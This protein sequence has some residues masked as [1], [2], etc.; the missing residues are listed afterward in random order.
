M[1][2][3]DQKKR[4]LNKY[5]ETESFVI[6][7]ADGNH[8]RREGKKEK[9]EGEKEKQE[10]GEKE[11]GKKLRIPST[12]RSPTCYFSVLF[13]TSSFLSSLSLLSLSSFSYL[14][15]FSLNFSF[16]PSLFLRL[17]LS[18]YVPMFGTSEARGH[19]SICVSSSSSS[20]DGIRIYKCLKPEICCNYN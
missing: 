1:I 13:T 9:Q 6:N 15:L 5:I 11:R 12:V 20:F 4:S 10:E 3:N 8:Q 2:I 19:E 18:F 17:F 14:S 7:D 16:S